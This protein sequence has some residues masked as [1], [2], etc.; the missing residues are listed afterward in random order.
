MNR[1]ILNIFLFLSLANKT[2]LMTFGVS[3][4]YDGRDIIF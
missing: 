2:F 4:A 3:E 1:N